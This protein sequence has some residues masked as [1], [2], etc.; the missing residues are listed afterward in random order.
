MLQDLLVKTMPDEDKE[1]LLKELIPWYL[2]S[3]KENLVL[4]EKALS[5]KDFAILID[6]G[7][8]LY[9]HGATFGF[10]FIS[11]LGKRIE[12]AAIQKDSLQISS[13]I[14]CLRNYLEEKVK[15]LN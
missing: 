8:K 7:D 4:L 15:N 10:P 14:K 3:E 12:V 5:E 1:D 2:S 11:I 9:G 13:L 6:L